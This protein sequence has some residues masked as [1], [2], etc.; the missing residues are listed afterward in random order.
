MHPHGDHFPPHLG[1]DGPSA[2]KTA[3]RVY[4]FSKTAARF[5]TEVAAGLPPEDCEVSM[6][7]SMSRSTSDREEDGLRLLALSRIPRCATCP[8]LA[9]LRANHGGDSASPVPDA[10]RACT[11]RCCEPL[12]KLYGPP[13]DEQ[14][15]HPRLANDRDHPPVGIDVSPRGFGHLFRGDCGN[16]LEKLEVPPR[17]PSVEQFQAVVHRL[18]LGR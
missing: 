9:A 14:A 5:P 7:G 4:Q 12:V 15:A 2:K 17:R 11:H 8:R 10:P 3:V 1:R 13:D 18:V 6:N 16:L